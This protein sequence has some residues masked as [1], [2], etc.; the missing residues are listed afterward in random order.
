MNA[1]DTKDQLKFVGKKM[2]ALA[3]ELAQLKNNRRRADIIA[4]IIRLGTFYQSIKSGD[5]LL[6]QDR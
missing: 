4:Q 6:L 2:A 3:V 5:D 1:M